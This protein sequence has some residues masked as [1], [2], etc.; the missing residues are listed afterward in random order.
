MALDGRSLGAKSSAVKRVVIMAMQEYATHFA[1]EVFK[2]TITRATA[3]VTQR[4]SRK[5]S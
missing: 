2:A 3:T 4:G 1:M 5:S